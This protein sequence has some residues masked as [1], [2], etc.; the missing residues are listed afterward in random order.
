MSYCDF[1]LAKQNS[2]STQFPVVI[3]SQS[4][5][6]NLKSGGRFVKVD[7]QLESLHLLVRSDRTE[8]DGKGRSNFSAKEFVL[9]EQSGL[10]HQQTHQ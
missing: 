3:G 8:Y 6:N 4:S 9:W 10:I 1:V 5:Q 7:C 2:I